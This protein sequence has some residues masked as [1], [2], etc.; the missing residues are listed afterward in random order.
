MEDANA[1]AD[2]VLSFARS[3]QIEAL[4]QAIKQNTV[5]FLETG[6][7][8]TLIAIMLLRS[9]AHSLRIPSPYKAIFLVPTVVLVSQQADVVEMH[10][11]LKVA[12]YWGEMGVD[13]WDASTWKQELE[14]NEVLVM[15]PMILLN[16]LRH[17]FITLEMIKVLIF[18][19]CHNAKKNHPYACIM[20]EF[21]HPQSHKSELPRIFGMTASPI[22]VKGTNTTSVYW[23]EIQLLENLM[24]SKHISSINEDALKEAA[25][26]SA[27]KKLEKDIEDLRC[28][29]FVERVVT[30]IAL[31][32]FLNELVPK[33]CNWKAKYIAGN[34]NVLQSQSRNEQKKIVEEFRRGKANI[35]VATSILEEGLDVQSCNLVIRFDPCSNVCSFIQ[36]RGRARMKNSDFLLMVKSGDA[37]ALAQAKTYLASVDIMREESLKHSSIPCKPIEHDLLDQI[38][39]RIESTG[40][41]VN[42]RSSVGL[43]YFYCS[44]LPSDGYFK[45][46]PRCTI[47]EVSET[48]TLQFPTS[49]PLQSVTVR[50]NSKLLKRLACLEACKKLHQ[51]GAL[52]DNLVPDTVV[53]EAEVQELENEPYNDEHT[54]YIPPELV[55]GALIE[56]SVLYHCYIIELK[57]GFV[58]NVPVNNLILVVNNELD[59]DTGSTLWDLEVNHGTIGVELKYLQ[60]FRFTR[61]L[62]HICEV[63]QVAIF[64]AL[65]NHS[66]DILKRTLDQVQINNDHSSFN[67]LIL[68]STGPSCNSPEIDWKCVRSVLFQ[69]N[70]VSSHKCTLPMGSAQVHTKNGSICCCM[71]ESCLVWTPHNGCMYCI[72]GS[73][74]LNS[75]S[76]MSLKESET[77]ITYKQY[78]KRQ[79]GIDLRFENEV[80][81]N[82]SPVFRIQSLLPRCRQERQKDHGYT[83]ELPPELCYVIMSPLSIA[84]VYTYSLVPLIMHRIES[85]LVG[86]N[87]KKICADHCMQNVDIPTMKVLEAI[88]TK[89]CQEAFHLESLE[90]LGDSFLKYAASQH[91][92]K[93]NQGQHEGLLSLKR[94]KIISNIS[95]C[96]L[97]CERMIPGFIRNHKFEA[98]N[99]P[100][101][102]DQNGS[103]LLEEE[104]ITPARKMYKRGTQNL[105]T[106]KVADV[107]E[108]L[109]GAYLSCGGEGAAL[110]FMNWLGIEMDFS[111]VPYDREFQVDPAVLVNINHFQ[112]LLKY[113]FRDPSLLVEALTH[114]SF[115]MPEISR[116]YQRLEFL[117]DSVLDH[118]ITLH[119]YSKY[120]GLSPGKLTDM[121]SASVN[122]ECY[123]Y[124]AI[125]AELHKHILHA[126]PKLHGELVT[127][128]T[129]FQHLLPESTFGWEFDAHF[130]K[131]LADIIESLAGAIFVDSGYNKDAVF[132]SMKPLLGQLV[133]PETL[134]IHPVQELQLVCQKYH[135]LMRKPVVCRQEN[136]AT[137]Y[138]LEVEANGIVH[139][140]TCSAT[141][142]N[143]AQ[144]I[145]SRAVLKSLKDSYMLHVYKC[146]YYIIYMPSY[147][148]LATGEPEPDQVG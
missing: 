126:S 45:S 100:I 40:A 135:F 107:V 106:K 119:L 29:I 51:M 104:W 144:K 15:T 27:H 82:A 116:S 102:G 8:K 128:L 145:A 48:C 16:A 21:Y 141:D 138:T 125:R 66:F 80:L 105:K 83:W 79:Y 22:K 78:F 54:I 10:T 89:K 58:S 52:N 129:S 59:L 113:T 6:S 38:F 36:S 49:C 20:K 93:T 24:S 50:G 99:W 14:K 112:N 115:M 9:Y 132:E 136:V 146:S 114:G 64:R 75:N 70:G 121:R 96:K 55:S 111:Y 118:L 73:L 108:A 88:T 33:Y 44:R 18:D 42:L 72:S 63:F 47:D 76:F 139:S 26:N 43:I 41:I 71:L 56:H 2:H 62:V 131:V 74:N 90:T 109:I 57:A 1:N 13:Y 95:L 110:S 87:L 148:E 68:P 140:H 97:G 23:K 4:E 32:S 92:F 3:Y 117:G 98:K 137:S 120:P 133:T 134:K 143:L 19:E 11:D 122:N 5:V 69:C 34:H 85:L 65:L 17:S 37:S 124:A 61:E 53:E 127:T 142:K 77:V 30:A 39:Y 84:T 46:V 123:A 94:E 130:P 91:L 12:K 25:E 28:I 103:N 67:Y 86:A 81:L 31:E 60:R 147:I 7:G 101:P 35:I